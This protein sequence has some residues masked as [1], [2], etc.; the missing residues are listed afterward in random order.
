LEEGLADAASKL[1]IERTSYVYRPVLLDANK[2]SRAS[3]IL[4]ASGL[5]TH[6]LH[7]E[8]FG[9][10]K[11]T[12]FRIRRLELLPAPCGLEFFPRPLFVNVPDP[13]GSCKSFPNFFFK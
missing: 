8:K 1:L 13:Q 10:L 4:G 9:N 7:P 5:Q 12:T 2:T 6:V 11:R 3:T